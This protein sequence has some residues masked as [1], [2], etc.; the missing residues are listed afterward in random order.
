LFSTNDY[1]L[2]ATELHFGDGSVMRNDFRNGKLNPQIDEAL[3]T[4]KIEP[5]F[6]V[7]EPIKR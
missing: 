6:K 5:D 7:V 3:F 1:T 4:P 2:R